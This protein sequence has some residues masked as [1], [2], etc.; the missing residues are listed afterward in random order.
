EFGIDNHQASVIREELFLLE[1]QIPFQVLELLVN[2]T[3]DPDQLKKDIA[4]FLRIN[5][6]MAPVDDLRGHIQWND[7]LQMK[8]QNVLHLL[9]L[10]HSL[11]IFGDD[12]VGSNNSKNDDDNLKYFSHCYNQQKN[13]ELKA[14]GIEFKPTFG[15]ATVS[16]GSKCFNIRGHLK[17]P[18]LT[19]DEWTDRKL[20]NLVI[21]EM[22]LGGNHK[23]NCYVVT[24][25]IK[26]MDFLIDREQDV[27]ELRASRVLWNCLSSD[28]EVAKL[29]NDLGSKCFEQPLDVYLNVKTEIQTH[30]ERKCSVWM[31]QVYQE[32]FSSPWTILALLAAAIVLALTAIQ[33]WYSI[34]PKN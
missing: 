24:S 22:C 4:S 18:P 7:I 19:M 16:F 34:H 12:N 20:M 2:L 30:C 6:I 31:A 28:A 32:H 17:L 14:A 8:K 29:F 9:D 1:N 15:L 23:K 13:N 3:N 21:Y 33:T 10:L 11:I 27:K 26:F 5:N 25:Y